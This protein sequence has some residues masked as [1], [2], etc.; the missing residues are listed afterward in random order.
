MYQVSAPSLCMIA[1][2]TVGSRWIPKAPGAEIHRSG[3][4]V[5][6]EVE[7]VDIFLREPERCA[8]QNH[9]AQRQRALRRDVIQLRGGLA[10]AEPAGPHGLF[11]HAFL[12]RAGNGGVRDVDG[13]VAEVYG[14]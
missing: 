2:P 6:L 7:L 11:R 5:P 14:V 1:S 3:R 12:Q 4:P 13:Q 10:S 8:Q 9:V